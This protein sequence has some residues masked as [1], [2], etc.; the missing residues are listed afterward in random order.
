MPAISTTEA[1]EKL[2][3]AV[4]KACSSD[5]PEIYSELYPTKS[6]PTDRGPTAMDLAAIIRAGIEPE[7]IVDLWHVIFPTAR[8]V[9]FDEEENVVR[10]NESEARYADR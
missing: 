8:K 9:Y 2:A 6:F 7:L 3:Q 1:I 10:Y 5:L 4:E